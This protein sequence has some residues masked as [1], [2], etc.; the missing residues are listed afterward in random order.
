M[1]HDHV[2]QAIERHFHLSN[3]QHRQGYPWTASQRYSR[4][5]LARVYADLGFTVGAEIGVRRGRYS[6]ILC[7]DIPGLR[8]TLIDP[9]APDSKYPLERQEAFMQLAYERLAPYRVTFLRKTSMA[10]L[11]DVPDASLDFIFI[12]ANHLFDFIMMD[13][14]CWVPKV[15]SGGIVSVHDYHCGE[16]GV[17]RAIEAYVGA[18]RIEPWYSTKEIESTAFWVNR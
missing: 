11:A 18:H 6:E 13:I 1:D 8:L 3:R 12:D 10:A 16:T 5:L 9:W 17:T 7:K 14:I 15:K 4:D 2:H